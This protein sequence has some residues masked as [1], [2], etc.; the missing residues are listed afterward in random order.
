LDFRN[1]FACYFNYTIAE[2][3]SASPDH[4]AANVVGLDGYEGAFCALTMVRIGL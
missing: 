4:H 3:F 1:W 2:K